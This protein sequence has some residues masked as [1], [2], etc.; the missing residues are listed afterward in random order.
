[1]RNVGNIV[2][3]LLVLIMFV[4]CGGSDEGSG[5]TPTFEEVTG[6]VYGESYLLRKTHKSCPSQLSIFPTN[7]RVVHFENSLFDIQYDFGDYTPYPIFRSKSSQAIAIVDYDRSFHNYEI[8]D[9]SGNTE[10]KFIEEVGKDMFICVDERIALQSLEQESLDIVSAVDFA[11]KSSKSSFDKFPNVEVKPINVTVQGNLIHY[12]HLKVDDEIIY[13]GE[14]ET[15]VDN[16]FYANERITFTPQGK[17]SVENTPYWQIPFVAAHEYGHHVFATFFAF[18]KKY[19]GS[20][21][22]VGCFSKR[23]HNNT[24]FKHRDKPQ[25]INSLLD[26]FSVDNI[27]KNK[28]LLSALNEGFADIYAR[29]A[30]FD[31]S[32]TIDCFKDSREV[33]SSKFAGQEDKI[34]TTEI[35]NYYVDSEKTY[36]GAT[37]C[38]DYNYEDSH[39]IG[40]VIVH[41]FH[42]M[43]KDVRLSRSERIFVL[44]KWLQNMNTVMEGTLF[45]NPIF[46]DPV[47]FVKWSVDEFIKS[48]QEVSGKGSLSANQQEIYSSV[49]AF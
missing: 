6:Y 11:Y 36:S 46:K 4:S 19:S 24:T 40:T 27:A 25:L 45:D 38:D 26:V 21:T 42:A 5:V 43:M 2:L 16:A 10:Y 33:D 18:G 28:R 14:G 47:V 39:H 9:L 32:L 15:V 1:M 48:L 34:L 49:F 3:L 12:Y 44:I 22:Q 13:E 30:S 31:Y 17:S 7:N 8:S 37:T 41:G 20:K 29:Y 35:I 23:A